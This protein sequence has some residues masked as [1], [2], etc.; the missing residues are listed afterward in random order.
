MNSPYGDEY[1][2]VLLDRSGSRG[3][4]VAR[5]A[6]E[7]HMKRLHAVPRLAFTALATG[8]LRPWWMFT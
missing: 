2:E 5:A 3:W 1:T 4:S 7:R 6:Y 8:A